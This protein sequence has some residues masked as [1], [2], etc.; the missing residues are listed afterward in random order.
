MQTLAS[1]YGSS[2]VAGAFV[3]VK[4]GQVQNIKCVLL[5]LNFPEIV[6]RIGNETN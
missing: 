3:E 4:Q 1:S 6:I 5:N 2:E